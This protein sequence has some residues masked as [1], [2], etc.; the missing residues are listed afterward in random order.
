MTAAHAGK[1]FIIVCSITPSL[2]PLCVSARASISA[3]VTVLQTL[4]CFPCNSGLGLFGIAKDMQVECSSWKQFHHKACRQVF[5]ASVPTLAAYFV[6]KGQAERACRGST[7]T[8]IAPYII[9]LG[10]DT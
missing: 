2:L 8:F 7:V 1:E 10:F 9:G 3:R 4:T 6:T 5:G